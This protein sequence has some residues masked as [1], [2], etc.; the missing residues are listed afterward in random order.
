MLVVPLLVSTKVLVLT[1]P[2]ED[3]PVPVPSA[4]QARTVRRLI[5]VHLP[6][7]LPMDAVRCVPCTPSGQYT[8]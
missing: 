4:I 3:M 2:R 5:I 7:A 8:L 6:L 1:V